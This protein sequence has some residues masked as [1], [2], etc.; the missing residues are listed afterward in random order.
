MTTLDFGPT[1]DALAALVRG[2]RDDQL[3]GPTPCP[4]RSV[5]DLLDHVAGLAL[6]FTAA[7]CKE[8]PPGGGNPT[9][10]AAALP[11]DWREEIPARLDALADGWRDP[12]AYSGYT[13]AGPIE[14]PADQ[15]VRVAL[16][17]VTVH[18]WD[19]AVATG[20]QYDADPAAVEACASFVAAFDA[21]R[22]GGLFGPEVEV[23]RSASSLDRLIGATGRDPGWSP[24]RPHAETG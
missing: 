10:D 13:Q 7:A 21:P 17:E 8:V 20:Q 5:G 2:V 22:A 3:D 9:A 14:M 11:D 4:G 23:E 18:A 1:T 24:S 6:A 12:A 19:L 16:D 15:A